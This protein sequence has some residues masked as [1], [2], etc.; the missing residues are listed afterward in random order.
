MRA[1]RPAQTRDEI[2]LSST[3]V[4]L[5]PKRRA[6]FMLSATAAGR[7]GSLAPRGAPMHTEI[8]F[9]ALFGVAAAVALM[10]RRLRVPYTV[11]LVVAGLLLGHTQ[12]L[13]APHLTKELLYAIFLPG[14]LFE[15]AFHLE[16]SDFWRNRTV[17]FGLAIPGLLAAI[18]L[19]ASLL[20][21]VASALHFVEGFTLIHG[22]VFAALIAATDPI[23]VVGLFKTMGVPRRLRVLV[24]GESLLNDG[25]A[26]VVFALITGAVDSGSFHIGVA[27]MDFVRVVGLGLFV[28]L[29][30][31]YLVSKVI[32]RVDDPMIE[33]TLT[34]IGAY[35]SFLIAEEFH[36]SGVIATV[37]A[38]MLC[39]NYGAR[40]GMSPTTRIAVESFWEYVAFAMNSIVFLLIGLEVQLDSLAA[41]W[42]AVLVAWLAVML[43]RAGA[44]SLAALA[45]SLTR[46]RLPRRWGHV[47]TWGGLRGALS[48]V[49]VLALPAGF[50][51]RQLLVNMTFGVVLISILIQGL[52]MSRLL[53][54][55]GVAG[56]Q[57]DRHEYE[58]RKGALLAA[59][60]ALS[61]LGK[62]RH[63]RSAP[64]A[65]LEQLSS[66][67][68]TRVGEA[69]KMMH[70]LQGQHARLEEE[71]AEAARRHLLLVEKD[72]LMRGRRE[73]IL[74]DEA[75]ERL[76]TDVD[77]RLHEL[78][79]ES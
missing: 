77:A 37:A 57:Q 8:V 11:A 31:G 63:S 74:S 41:S 24:E 7:V 28:G 9:V 12:K 38:G 46:Q 45:L 58:Q 32:Q 42:L 62:M 26:V 10:A 60:A 5:C 68:E 75:Y 29:L 30:G 35:G 70:A 6:P 64:P 17:I 33:I 78:E 49:L 52:S 73:G 71:E 2:P 40:T 47:M 53:T 34:T 36:V 22:L 56:A 54:R 61:A 20:T 72:E 13:G 18:A 43:G 51:H 1:G 50:V 3:L 79:K 67:Y 15:A 66:E 14:L 55:W 25:T 21:P 27:A 16:F 23:A 44:V 19:T 69:E 65:V 59:N 4:R 39:G 48:M 76:V